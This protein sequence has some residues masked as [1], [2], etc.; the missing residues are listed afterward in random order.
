MIAYAPDDEKE[1]KPLLLSGYLNV[2]LCYLKMGEHVDAREQCNKA[3][4]LDPTSE[5]G[6]FRRYVTECVIK[7]FLDKYFYVKVYSS[8]IFTV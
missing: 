4:E 8:M 3:L 6:L 2:A 7:L 1:R 5:K